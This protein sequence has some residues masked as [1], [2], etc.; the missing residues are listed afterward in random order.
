MLQNTTHTLNKLRIEKLRS[1]RGAEKIA[2]AFARRRAAVFSP[3]AKL[4]S[5]NDSARVS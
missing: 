5:C 4:E 3:G 1:E 2:Q